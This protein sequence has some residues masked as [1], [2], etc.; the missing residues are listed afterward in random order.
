MRQDILTLRSHI[1]HDERWSEE[2]FQ[3]ALSAEVRFNFWQSLG[4]NYLAGCLNNA[5]NGHLETAVFYE[6]SVHKKKEQLALL[7]KSR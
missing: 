2:F 5:R 4:L 1:N 3:M 7:E 6:L